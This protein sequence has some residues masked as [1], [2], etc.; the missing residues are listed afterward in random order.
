MQGIISFLIIPNMNIELSV[1]P[2]VDQN[3]YK[4]KNIVHLRALFNYSPQE[5]LYIPCREL[6]LSFTKGDIL[7]ITNQDDEN[8]WQAYRDDDKDQQMA[9]LIPSQC[10]QEKRLSQMHAIIG[11]S[12]MSRK[13][14]KKIF[15]LKFF[16]LNLN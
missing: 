2:S 14:S 7:H 4:S 3:F 9:G 15:R 11:D 16:L 1:Q 10:F 8:W 5:D 6:G 13:N 12:F